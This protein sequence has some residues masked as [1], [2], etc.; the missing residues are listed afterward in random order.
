LLFGNYSVVSVFSKG[1]LTIDQSE[2]PFSYLKVGADIFSR[3]E[4][5]DEEQGKRGSSMCTA[6]QAEH[7]EE[8]R[9]KIK[10]KRL[11]GVIWSSD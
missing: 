10:P 8:R 6:A 11:F 5:C 2:S 3:I 4:A 7:N 1:A 9:K